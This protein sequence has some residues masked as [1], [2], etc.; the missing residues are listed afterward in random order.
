VGR[1]SQECTVVIGTLG[2]LSGPTASRGIPIFRG[3]ELAVNEA[4]AEGRLECDLELQIEDTNG[5]PDL[6]RARARGLA[7][8]RRVVACMCGYTSDEAV[9]AGAPLSAAGVLT[10]GPASSPAVAELG[11]DSWFSAA[12]NRDVETAGTVAYIRDVLSPQG[13]GV[14][15]DGTTAG[16]DQADAIAE[17]LGGLVAARAQAVDP[18]GDAPGEILG[19]SPEVVYVGGTGSGPAGIASGLRREGLEAV[20]VVNSEALVSPAP[21]QIP[22]AGFL[23]VCPCVDA[24]VLP[25]GEAF[26]AAFRAAYDAPP[27]PYSAE[28]YDVTR[29]VI[30]ALEGADADTD[31]GSLRAMVVAAFEEAEG[32]AGISGPLTWSNTGVMEADPPRDV[33]VYEWRG[34]TGAFAPLA[35]VGQLR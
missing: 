6:A 27:G 29:L 19:L 32:A 22:D 35:P 18:S 11:F 3:V 21:G 12:P 8:G 23:V 9:A 34:S 28:M 20:F 25:E 24:S 10:S 15:D 13:V 31:I 7:R 17:D 4:D 1:S 14:V 2:D 16:V 33:W 30:D 5:D 26:T